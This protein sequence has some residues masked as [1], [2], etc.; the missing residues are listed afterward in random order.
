MPIKGEPNSI[1]DKVDDYGNTL[2]RRKHGPD[3]MAIVD[4]DTSDHNLPHSHPTGAYKHDFDYSK[5]SPR[6]APKPLTEQELNENE[7]IIKKGVN[8]HDEE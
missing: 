6:R 7:D 1:V 5:K 4:Y 3:G 2:Q 8:Y